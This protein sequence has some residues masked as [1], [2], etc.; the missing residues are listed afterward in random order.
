MTP[1]K[2]LVWKKETISWS[3]FWSRGKV[4]IVLSLNFWPYCSSA[5]LE[6]LVDIVRGVA[7]EFGVLRGGMVEV[8]VCM[9][10]LD[11]Q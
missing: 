4:D 10:L 3:C 11:G 5:G 6:L 2:M 1:G 7:R 9:V 8:D